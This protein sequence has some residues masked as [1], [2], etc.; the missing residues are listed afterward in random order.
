MTTASEWQ[1]HLQN[2]AQAL[3]RSSEVPDWLKMALQDALMVAP[4]LAPREEAEPEPPT[5][6]Y[7]H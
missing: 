1:T 4:A 2:A 6:Y 7:P 5:F 3:E